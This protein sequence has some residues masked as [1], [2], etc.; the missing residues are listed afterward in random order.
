MRMLSYI[1]GTVDQ[2]LLLRNE[3]LAAENRILRVKRVKSV[4]GCCCL[5]RKRLHWPKLP[6]LILCGERSLKRA[7]HHYEMHYHQERNHQGKDNLMLFLG[8]PT[9]SATRKGTRPR[10]IG[11]SAQIL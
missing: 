9:N 2:K 1:T 4:A 11:W 5:I 7:L 10:A 8:Q 3:Y 6:K